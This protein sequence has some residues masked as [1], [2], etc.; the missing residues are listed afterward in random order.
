MAR[1]VTTIPETLWESVG[2]ERPRFFFFTPPRSFLQFSG[3][4]LREGHGETVF[5]IVVLLFFSSHSLDF[6]ERKV[7]SHPT[8]YCTMDNHFYRMKL[9]FQLVKIKHFLGVEQ[10]DDTQYKVYYVVYST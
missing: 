1:K 6:L 5:N 8:F 2:W 3:S 7:V 9:I 4:S 10:V